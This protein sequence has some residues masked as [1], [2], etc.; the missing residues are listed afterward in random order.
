[1]AASGGEFPRVLMSPAQP[2]EDPGLIVRIG[3]IREERAGLSQAGDRLRRTVRAGK[4]LPEIDQCERDVPGGG[5]LTVCGQRPHEV[6]NSIVGTVPG[7]RHEAEPPH[8]AG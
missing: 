5:E 1:M 2:Y 6:F 3:D 4:H 8:A 7:Y